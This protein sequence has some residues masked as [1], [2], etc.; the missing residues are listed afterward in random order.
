MVT[1]RVGFGVGVRARD[2]VKVRVRL[3][4]K[5]GVSLAGLRT[6][7]ASDTPF[8]E[9]AYPSPG[10]RTKPA[11]EYGAMGGEPIFQCREAARKMYPLT[12]CIY[13]SCPSPQPIAKNRIF[14]NVKQ[15]PAPHILK[16]MGCFV[17]SN[18]SQSH[19]H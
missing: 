7:P 1:V 5:N 14:C 4:I 11:R 15:Q 3:Y 12:V 18:S 2:R 8:F 17:K 16:T 6:K 13:A 10:I 19:S 9:P